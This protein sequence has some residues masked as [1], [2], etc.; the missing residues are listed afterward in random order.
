MTNSSESVCVPSCK[1]LLPTA[2]IIKSTKQCVRVCPSGTL[3]YIDDIK[4]LHPECVALCSEGS[5]K[6]IDTFT[7]SNLKVCTKLCKTLEP[8]AY[9]DPTVPETCVHS[10][11]SANSYVD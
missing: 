10:C 1:N 11:P 3:P 5:N 6:L 4:A 8:V 7:Y 2:Y 9:I